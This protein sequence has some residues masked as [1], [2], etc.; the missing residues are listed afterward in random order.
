M[1]SALFAQAS[2]QH[3]KL[4][5]SPYEYVECL[6]EDAFV[7]GETVILT[8]DGFAPGELVTL[9]FVQGEAE[10][11]LPPGKADA[12]GSLSVRVAIPSDAR[13]GEEARIRALGKG[14]QGAGLVLASSPLLIFLD[15][16]DTDGDGLADMCDNCPTVAGRDLSD[17]DYDG[18]GDACDK[19]PL[20]SANDQ[21]GD[22]L[23][24]DVDP[25]PYEAQPSS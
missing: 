17:Q 14:R 19:C 22:G 2:G 3:G 13:T 11:A 18:L 25:V 7:L 5:V 21:D 4:F 23:C 8:G 9:V 16:R 12:D 1:A 10:H 6:N 20:D 15:R 24:A